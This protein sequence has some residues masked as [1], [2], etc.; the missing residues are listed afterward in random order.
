MVVEDEGGTDEGAYPM[1]RGATNV[2]VGGAARAT[3][4]PAG[5]SVNPGTGDLVAIPP[6][7]HNLYGVKWLNN[8]I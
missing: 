3:L 4:N 6:N 2:T 1:A 8:Y 5:G 7:F